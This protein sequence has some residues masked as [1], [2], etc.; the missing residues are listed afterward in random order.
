M[1]PKAIISLFSILVM[2]FSAS[3]VLPIAVSLIFKDSA[4]MIFVSTFCLVF[5]LGLMGWLFS[6]GDNDELGQKDG[7]I[8]ITFF[9]LILAIA[10]SIPFALSSFEY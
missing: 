9:W 2:F 6:R 7:F 3:F 8:I 1:N 4:L 10:G 5:G